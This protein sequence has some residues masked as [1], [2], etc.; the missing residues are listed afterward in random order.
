MFHETMDVHVHVHTDMYTMH[1][2]TNYLISKKGR[3]MSK[4]LKTEIKRNRLSSYSKFKKILMNNAN[5][6][7]CEQDLGASKSIFVIK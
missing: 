4:Q 7:V 2:H 6:C 1:T 3:H 5:V